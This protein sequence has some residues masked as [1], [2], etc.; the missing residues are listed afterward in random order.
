MKQPLKGALDAFATDNTV[1]AV[2]ASF[3]HDHNN[4]IPL[5]QELSA[6][7]P[8]S[9]SNSCHTLLKGQLSNTHTMSGMW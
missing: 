9:V 2:I 1:T 7:L 8:V 6:L 5:A 4:Y 3:V